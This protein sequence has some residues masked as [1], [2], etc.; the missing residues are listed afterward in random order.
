MA[1]VEDFKKFAFKG[2]V[3]D[4]AVGV[5]IGGAFGKIV[6][7]LVENLIMPLIAVVM[8]NPDWKNAS[9][10]LKEIVND[11]GERVMAKLNYG[12]F[13]GNIVDF[14]VIALVLFFIVQAATKAMKKKEEAPAAPPKSEV[15]LE[16]IRDL[17]KKQ[18][19]PTKSDS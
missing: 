4:L 6:T 2:N 8:P 3:L 11:K 1:F 7:G 9:I 5:I 17:L 16:E 18:A 14:I 15:L 13:L 19:A 12:A 10:P